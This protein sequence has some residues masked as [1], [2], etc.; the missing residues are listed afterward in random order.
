M[1]NVTAG[2][3]R[4]VSAADQSL[5][6]AIGSADT[7]EER[8]AIVYS[9]NPDW[10]DQKWAFDSDTGW[11]LQN[12]ATQKYA[13]VYNAAFVQGQPVVQASGGSDNMH[14]VAEQLT[15]VTYQGESCACVILKCRNHETL[16]LSYSPDSRKCQLA[17]YSENDT[18]QR[19]ILVPTYGS[20]SDMTAPY[21]LGSSADTST[22]ENGGNEGT[23]SMTV[24]PFWSIDPGS[25]GEVSFRFREQVRAMNKATVWKDWGEWTQWTDAA[26]VQDGNRFWLSAG[27]T[28]YPNAS[29]LVQHRWQVQAIIDDDGTEYASAVSEATTTF[30]PLPVIAWG[31]S[32]W[33]LD[34]LSIAATSSYNAKGP[35]T[36]YIDSVTDGGRE[37]LAAPVKCMLYKGVTSIS[38]AQSDLQG[39]PESGDVLAIAYRL[40][41][42]QLALYRGSWAAES[43]VSYS[44]GDPDVRPTVSE[45]AGKVLEYTFGYE[46]ERMWLLTDEG[47]TECERENG[48]FTVL[49]PF[50]KP[51]TVF[52]AGRNEDGHW[53]AYSED[54]LDEGAGHVFNWEGG[55]AVLD[56][57][58]GQPLTV[59]DAITPVYEAHTYN[60]RDYEDYSFMHN[61]KHT[62]TVPAAIVDGASESAYEDLE[63]LGKA[64][65]V[66]YRNPKSGP[67]RVA[68]LDVKRGAN[69]DWTSVDVQLARES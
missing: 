42:D 18:R 52:A 61:I 64:H 60:G 10:N 63:A 26:V 48:T 14:W 40:G 59:D 29:K 5:S 30:Y 56:L 55:S 45:G 68:V 27:I 37:L 24:Y 32:S 46:E 33:S 57:R 20:R 44:G 22:Y 67:M 41:T 65:H 66:T 62:F 39:I 3:Y 21:D 49:Y 38:I 8:Q 16:A 6:F 43:T 9:T 4:L 7:A 15:D 28:G 36:V 12:L 1:A 17:A 54:R 58:Q 69:R 53:F 50:G 51:Y 13:V 35:T 31:G 11:T 19:W 47:L 23:G 34:G 25:A 2:L